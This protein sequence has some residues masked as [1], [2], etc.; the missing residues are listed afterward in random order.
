MPG[1]VWPTKT[2]CVLLEHILTDWT[3][4]DAL[5]VLKYISFY[6]PRFPLKVPLTM[7]FF[8]MY[9]FSIPSRACIEFSVSITP[10][11]LF[12]AWSSVFS[13]WSQFFSVFS[14]F[15]GPA[16]SCSRLAWEGSQGNACL[17]VYVFACVKNLLGR[18]IYFCRFQVVF[19][20]IWNKSIIFI[21]KITLN[22]HSVFFVPTLENVCV[23]A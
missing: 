11:F 7:F 15:P 2:I 9:K 3:G 1:C 4:A 17:S 14:V 8:K 16:V 22:L 20:R 10:L 13:A 6:F 5:Y 23:N 19:N 18:C 12:Y 21:A